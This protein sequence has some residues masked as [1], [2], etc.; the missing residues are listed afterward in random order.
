MGTHLQYQNML[1]TFTSRV[2]ARLSRHSSSTP[3][4]ETSIDSA[5]GHATLS[6][7]SPPVNSLSLPLLTQL[8]SALGT[9]TSS[10]DV[11]GIVLTSANPGVFSAG[12]DITAMAGADAESASAF[13]ASVQAVWLAL[14]GCPKPVVAAING[15]APAGGCLLAICA[16]ARVMGND[17]NFS[18]GLNET[19]LGIVAPPWFAAPY[20]ALLGDAVAEKHLCLG[21]M[22]SAQDA[23]DAGLVDTLVPTADVVESAHQTLAKYVAVPDAA[24]AMTKLSLRERVLKS[25]LGTKEGRERDMEQFLGLVLSEPVQ[26][27]LNA[28]LAALKSKSK[29]KA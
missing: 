15:H 18:I 12:L 27:T 20:A 4:V 25:T 8:G 26:A 11:K 14:Y 22:L 5:T 1:R 16:D 10:P 17:G 23:L 2:A 28:Y 6:L 13:W 19:Q 9:A 24:R 3:L 21:S 29:S 7:A